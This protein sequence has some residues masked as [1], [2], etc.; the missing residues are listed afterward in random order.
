M[1]RSRMWY[2]RKTDRQIRSHTEMGTLTHTWGS[3][4]VIISIANQTH[5]DRQ[6]VRQSERERYWCRLLVFQETVWR[7]SITL[8]YAFLPVSVHTLS[9]SLVA[10]PLCFSTAVALVCGTSSWS[11]SV[12]LRRSNT[13]QLLPEVPQ[14]R[15]CAL[16]SHV[17]VVRNV[18]S[19]SASSLVTVTI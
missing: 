17:V 2:M 9:V 13:T 19:Q 15:P 7:I 8:H 3:R 18:Y 6:R 4:P 1:T 16:A 5:R 14:S 12:R 11:R 10:A